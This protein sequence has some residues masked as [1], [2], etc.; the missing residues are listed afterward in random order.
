MLCSG[1]RKRVAPGTV[2]IS[3]RYS[4]ERLGA[5]VETHSQQTQ[6]LANLDKMQHKIIERLNEVSVPCPCISLASFSSFHFFPT[7]SSAEL[8]YACLSCSLARSLT[9]VTVCSIYTMLA[10]KASGVDMPTD[11]KMERRE[12]WRELTGS[13]SWAGRQTSE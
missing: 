5:R 12:R 4:V 1:L 8:K 3:L 9:A 10:N 13:H 11:G 7:F 2:S 6:P